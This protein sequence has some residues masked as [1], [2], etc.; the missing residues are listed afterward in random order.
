MRAP[1]QLLVEVAT[2]GFGVRSEAWR[3]AEGQPSV[4]SARLEPGEAA[5]R[6]GGEVGVDAGDGP[7]ERGMS[8]RAALGVGRQ[9]SRLRATAQTS[10]ESCSRDSKEAV[11]DSLPA[12]Q[13]PRSP[14]DASETER[15]VP[16]H[17]HITLA[18]RLVPSPPDTEN[19]TCAE[20]KWAS[21]DLR[22]PS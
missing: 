6:R 7:R 16:F 18:C 1:G 10:L 9:G 3:P 12:D 15:N 21:T 14:N 19:R 5:L 20:S 8:A 22:M 17:P 13:R 2:L 4:G 11:T